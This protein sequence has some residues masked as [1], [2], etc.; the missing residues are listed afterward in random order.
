[1]APE[2]NFGAAQYRSVRLPPALTLF[3]P[4]IVARGPPR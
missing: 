2:I 1:M 4:E 3:A